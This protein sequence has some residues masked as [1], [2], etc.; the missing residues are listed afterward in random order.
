MLLIKPPSAID[1]LGIV[2][3][4]VSGN[5]DRKEVVS[6][7]KAVHEKCGWD[8]PI[9]FTAGY[10]YFY[11]L[12]YASMPYPDRDE[13][14]FL[15]QEDFL[16]YQRDLGRLPGESLTENVRYLRSFEIDLNDIRWPMAIVNDQQ[17]VMAELPSVRGTFEQ[18][19]DMVEHCHLQFA[20]AR[21]LFVKQFDEMMSSVM[22]L[23][24]NRDPELLKRLMSELGVTDYMFP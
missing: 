12:M 17:D 9:D 24:N 20:E 11:S 3:S 19:L 1:L 4:L 14:C 5:L 2:G 21:Y 22:V 16:E 15:R 6:W 18:H 23:S 13:G 8:L 7:Q 10:W